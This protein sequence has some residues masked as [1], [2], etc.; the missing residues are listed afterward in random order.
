MTTELTTVSVGAPLSD[1][2]TILQNNPIHHVPVVNGA[3]PVGMVASSDLLR[4]VYDI[5]GTDERMVRTLLDHQFTLEDAMS[6][7]LLTLP[8]SATIRQAAN[9]LSD[10]SR[11]SVLVLDDQGEL[12]GIVTSTDL[13]RFLHEVL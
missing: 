6:T 1:V 11:H 5:E 7:D 3:T 4:L 2:Y 8:A 10:S 9:E 13:I 12:A